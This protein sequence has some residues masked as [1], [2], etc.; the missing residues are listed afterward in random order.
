[1]TKRLVN[2]HPDWSQVLNRKLNPGIEISKVMPNL[3]LDSQILELSFL[4]VSS[5]GN[6]YAFL[7]SF[8]FQGRSVLCLSLKRCEYRSYKF[9]IAYF[10]LWKANTMATELISCILGDIYF[11]LWVRDFANEEFKTCIVPAYQC[12]CP[13]QHVSSS[14]YSNGIVLSFREVA[15]CVLLND[16]KLVR[17]PYTTAL[18]S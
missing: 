5:I 8:A 9:Y 11:I 18:L 3:I 12:P 15:F 7:F 1:M 10:T 13:Q 16:I 14:F 2:V 4:P 17:N 6:Q